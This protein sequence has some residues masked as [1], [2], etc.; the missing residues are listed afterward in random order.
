MIIVILLVMKML[1]GWFRHYSLSDNNVITYYT[2]KSDLETFK[3][4]F[5]ER[6]WMICNKVDLQLHTIHNKSVIMADL[7]VINGTAYKFNVV[8]YI[9]VKRFINIK[10]TKEMYK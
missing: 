10:I 8:D 9:K 4:L 2:K 5:N 6:N 7:F 3:R 1:N